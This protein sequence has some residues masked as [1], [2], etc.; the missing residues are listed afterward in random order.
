MFYTK[1]LNNEYIEELYDNYDVNYLKNID[2]DNFNKIY[3]LLKE[4]NFNYIEDIILNY[5]N[6][7]ELEYNT[8]EIRIKNLIKVLGSNY[9]DIIGENMNYLEYIERK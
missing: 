8:V 1:Y 5:L 6:I 7:F 2:Q 3:K 9:V 4:Y